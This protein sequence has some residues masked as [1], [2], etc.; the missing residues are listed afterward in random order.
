M[1]KAQT[2]VKSAGLKP[3]G[4]GDDSPNGDAGR[5]VIH[6]DG[7]VHHPADD[8]ASTRGIISPPSPDNESAIPTI[9]I[10][11]HGD[12][13]K[14]KEGEEDAEEAD[15]VSTPVATSGVQRPELAAADSEKQD[16]ESSPNSSETFSF[17]NK[18]LCERWLDNLFM[19]L[20]EVSFPLSHL[21]SA[22][23]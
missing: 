11:E 5:A 6:E 16:G 12:E 23:D 2:D 7:T 21:S 10:S 1:Q 3:N 13:E 18:R 15:I 9:K 4:Y 22:M 8:R 19:V 17:S 20:Y 14:K